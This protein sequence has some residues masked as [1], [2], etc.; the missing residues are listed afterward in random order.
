MKTLKFIFLSFVILCAGRRSIFFEKRNLINH[1]W[2]ANDVVE[3]Y[4][5]SG[6]LVFSKGVFNTPVQGEFVIDM[7]A[8]KSGNYILR[9]GNRTAKV[10][11]K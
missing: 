3:L 2:Q 7:S 11:K 10:V 4:D 5:M 9:I 1:D 8:F 6:R